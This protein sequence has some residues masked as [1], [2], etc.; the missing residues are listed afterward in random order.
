MTATGPL[1]YDALRRTL[2]L[3][4]A[5]IEG[6]AESDQQVEDLWRTVQRGLSLLQSGRVDVAGQVA[7]ELEHRVDDGARPLA[8]PPAG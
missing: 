5:G 2:I 8:T 7:L 6:L 3:I 4:G 1:E